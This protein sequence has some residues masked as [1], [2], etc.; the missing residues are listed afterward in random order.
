MSQSTALAI[1]DQLITAIAP[2]VTKGSP[3]QIA[4]KVLHAYY[5]NP[6][7]SRCSYDSLVD[8]VVEAL[9]VGLDPTGQ[10]GDGWIVPF[11]GKA[12]FVPGYR[13]IVRL[14][15]QSGYV[16]SIE[17]HVVYEGDEFAID[18]GSEQVL[19]HKVAIHQDRGNPIGVYAML[20]LKDNPRPVVEWMTVEEIERIRKKSRAP[21]S[22]AWRDFWT[23]MA[24]RTPLK[25]LCKL[26]PLESQ[27]MAV[28]A[29]ADEAE[30]DFEDYDDISTLPKAKRVLERMRKALPAL[31]KKSVAEEQQQAAPTSTP[32]AVASQQ[33]TPSELD[34]PGLDDAV[35]D[36]SNVYDHL[37][38]S[39]TSAPSRSIIEQ[40]M[41]EIRER[42]DLTEEQKMELR[43]LAKNVWKALK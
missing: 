10:Y 2:F 37:R 22:P 43:D 21:D 31:D 5:R 38:L 8:A 14:A 29:Q 28:L 13:G 40:I 41:G 26:L 9:K 16:R 23:E 27:A 18:Y 3:E 34:G 25:R 6:E 7:L 42:T 30:Y 35:L 19:T 4:A 12:V 36:S 15:I 39:I 1:R 11:K 32:K 20:F 17:A 33:E 24:K